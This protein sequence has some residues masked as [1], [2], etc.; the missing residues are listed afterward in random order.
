MEKSWDAGKER[1]RNHGV[2]L[3]RD[4]HL[5]VGR[6]DGVL[7]SRRAYL[8]SKGTETVEVCWLYHDVGMRFHG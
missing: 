5:A 2:R 4:I 6:H 8:A 3:D 7:Q 1:A